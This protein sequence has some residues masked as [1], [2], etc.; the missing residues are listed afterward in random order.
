MAGWIDHWRAATVAIG[1]RQEYRVQSPGGRT[2]TKPFFAID[3]TG[4]LFSLYGTR[5]QTTWLVTAKHVLYDPAENWAPSS[6]GMMFSQSPHGNGRQALEIP[7][8]LTKGTRRLWYP[9]PDESVDLACLPVP[10]TLRPSKTGALTSIAWMDIATKSDL[11]EGVP[12]VVLGYPTA[13]DLPD[14]PRA[15]VRQG[16]VSWVSPSR[17]GSEVFLIDSH[18]FPGN[19][20][21]PVFRL[22]AVMNRQGHLATAGTVALLGIVTQA[23]IQILPLMAGGKQV[24]LHLE[25]RKASEPLLAL[26]YIGLGM[27]EPAYRIKQLLVAASSAHA[28][29]KRSAP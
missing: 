17:P 6:L 16:I 20:G 4:V 19:S 21:G 24:E 15:I 18:V 8:Q 2:S 11:Y 13:F 12:V 25:D 22:P 10:L 9:H 28:R 7:L 27:V 26:S 5:A 1:H 23:R 14:S 3:G 29:R